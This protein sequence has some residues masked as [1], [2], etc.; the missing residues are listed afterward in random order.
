MADVGVH[1]GETLMA[2]V[3]ALG[4]GAALGA[5]PAC[6]WARR[7]GVPDARHPEPLP[8]PPTTRPLAGPD[9]ITEPVHL[10]PVTSDSLDRIVPSPRRPGPA[11]A[12]LATEETVQLRLPAGKSSG[13]D[14]GKSSG[15]NGGVDGRG[16]KAPKAR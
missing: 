10:P 11:P 1:F 6:W 15:K 13:K 12:D 5:L 2:A 16:R 3:V 7:H 4:I 14:A 9:D 8:Q